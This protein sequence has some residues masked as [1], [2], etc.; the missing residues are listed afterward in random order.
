MW[1]I[2]KIFGGALLVLALGGGLYLNSQRTE[3]IQ[4]AL[5]RAEEIASKTLGVPVKIGSVDLDKVN[6]LDFD[7]ES[8]LIVHDVEIFDKNSE[9]IAK[10]DTAEVNFKL[11]ALRDDPVAAL[12]TIKIDG[13]LVNLKKRDENSWNVNDIKIESEGESTFGA[14]IYLERGTVNADF[15][16]KMPAKLIAPI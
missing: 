11:I 16:D 14:K 6:F 10:V 2:L 1:K 9:L 7:K 5:T 3:I 4:N 8:D 15:D 13:A 12:D